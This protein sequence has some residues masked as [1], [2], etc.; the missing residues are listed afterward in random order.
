MEIKPAESLRR[1]R[2]RVR[3]LDRRLIR[4]LTE[5]LALTNR[6]GQTK[7]ALGRPIMDQAAEAAVMD[8]ALRTGCAQ[9]L[10]GDL[11]RSL[12]QTIIAG[13]R[14]EQQKIYDAARARKPERILIV[15]GA[16][17][18][19][20]WFAAFLRRRG[21]RVAIYDLKKRGPRSRA[22][23]TLE[24]GLRKTDL[25]L[26][27]VPLDRIA[28]ILGR[29]AELRFPGI[30]CDIAS[31]KG[32]IAGALGSAR[33]RGLKVT[34]IH[35]LFGPGTRDLDRKTVCLCPCG[36][37]RADQRIRDLFRG[38]EIR[39]VSLSLEEH[40]R[41]ISYVLGLSHVVNLIFGAVLVRSRRSFRRFD[42]VASTTFRRQVGT[43]RSVL[44]EDPRL[45]YAI[46]RLNPDRARLYSDLEKTA[47]RVTRIVASG[48][49][50]EFIRLM[51][52]GR[53]WLSAGRPRR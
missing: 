7:L 43:A 16:G 49:E 13:S 11:V 26:I 20:K 48:R 52:S 19:G 8:R 36:S 9:G 32:H 17:E 2:R 42:R 50:S 15:G 30:V 6:I 53:K 22:C 23:R 44:D 1:R 34:S 51:E 5:R 14:F 33:Q 4:L 40:D 39:L 24:D 35:P 46:Q 21:H 27:S 18:M 28:V 12:F 25:V 29:L 3:K 10:P 47:R 38:P 45:Y 37:R 31:I 41:L